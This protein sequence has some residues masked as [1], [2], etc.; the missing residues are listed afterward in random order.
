MYDPGFFDVAPDRFGTTSSKWSGPWAHDAIPM[1]V[2]DMDFYCALPI[3]QALAQRVARDGFGYTDI[4]D[5]DRQALCGFLQRRHQIAIQPQQTLM[6]P[7]V[8]AGLRCAFHQLCRPGDGIVLMPPVYGP[9][10]AAIADSGM[11]ILEA[12]LQL[13]AAQRYQMDYAVI[14]DHLRAGCRLVLLCNPHNPVS[15]PWSQAE[16]TQL[17]QLAN[18]YGARIVSDE[19]H[20][21]FVYAPNRFVSMLNISEVAGSAVVLS[22]VSKTFNIAGLKQATLIT[23]DAQVLQAL[24][25]YIERTGIESGNLFALEATR[26]AYTQC[27]D[28]LDALLSYL[29]QNREALQAQLAQALP[30]AHVSP[31]EATYLA[32][33]D[34]RAYALDN[35]AVYD[36]CVSQGVIPT[37]GAVYSP[38]WGQGFMRLNFGCPRP[39]MQ[40]GIS[41]FA[42]AVQSLL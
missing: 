20:A 10:F 13:D 8:V 39:M 2:A 38:R 34:L 6:L 22:S 17:A 16:L 21:D 35:Q 28:W 12:P 26:A 40:E 30:L 41:R 9:F 25:Q 19:I 24:A 27:D 15:R 29:A 4:T 5:D 1:W 37:N 3:R 42:Q 7:S 23:R 14:E 11:R 33:V 32:W 18:Q 31:V 36:R